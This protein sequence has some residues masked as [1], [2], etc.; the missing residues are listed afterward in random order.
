MLVYWSLLFSSIA[1]SF[2]T[3]F[4]NASQIKWLVYTAFFIFI[5]LLAGF[6]LDSIDYGGYLDLFNETPIT[7]FAMPFF[8]TSLG[9]TGMEFLWASF[10]ATFQYLGL[11]FEAW[12]FF[13]A[14]VSISIKYHLFKKFTPYY[15]LALVL[16][17]SLWFSKDLGQIRNGLAAA[18]L[19]FSVEPLVKRQFFRFALVVFVAFGIQAYAIIALPLYWFY[20]ICKKRSGL[21]ALGLIAMSVISL[22]GGVAEITLQ[23]AKNIGF[24]PP[25]IVHKLEGYT[26]SSSGRISFLTYT[27]FVYLIFAFLFLY[28]KDRLLKLPSHF[29]A[30]AVIHI[31]SMYLFLFFTGI[32]TV[33]S[34]SLNLF[35]SSSL[36]I[37]LLAPLYFMRAESR[38]L[39]AF[40][41]MLFAV[42]SFY[43]GIGDLYEY[44]SILF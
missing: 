32:D 41:L 30:L 9:T 17:I 21:I 22:K 42:L 31:Y 6:R 27:G 44:K 33:T 12:V 15:L 2:V 25:G 3:F 40:G 1:A 20:S 28:F 24:I 4:R 23:T 19:L 43:K 26:A 10:S 29:F 35:S 37:V 34:R 13:V 39:Y 11:P 36:C 5:L 8:K 14:L 7:D 16:Y 18:I 38:L